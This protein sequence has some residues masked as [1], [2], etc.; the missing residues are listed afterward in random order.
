MCGCGPNEAPRKAA[1]ATQALPAA[2]TPGSQ[3]QSVGAATRIPRVTLLAFGTRDIGS[4]TTTI[5]E[6]VA[7]LFRNRMAEL[8]YVEGTT[9][10]IEE[11][12]ADGDPQRLTQLAYEIVEG[13]PDVIVTIAAAA[14]GAA[15]QAT[16][17]IPIVMAHAGNPVGSGLVASLAVRAATL[18]V[19]RRWLR[20]SDSSRSSSFAS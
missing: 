15:R 11:R 1:D 4:A 10:L 9:I 3:K 2:A 5:R 6:P 13:K 17:T 14:T 19:R 16:S 12:Y 8:G 7:M 18:P 20:S